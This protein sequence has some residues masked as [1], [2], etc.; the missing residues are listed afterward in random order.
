LIK[1]TYINTVASEPTM[2]LH[3]WHR[4][5]DNF[6]DFIRLFSIISIKALK[7]KAFLTRMVG[8]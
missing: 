2:S 8:W 3:E 6:D 5:Q 1:A 7:S 4:L